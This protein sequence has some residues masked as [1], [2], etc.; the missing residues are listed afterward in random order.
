MSYLDIDYFYC[1]NTRQNFN[2]MS[3]SVIRHRVTNPNLLEYANKNRNEG[4]FND[5]TIFAG[6]ESIPAN[7]L[8]LSCH[9]KFFEGMLKLILREENTIEIEVIDGTTMKALIDFIYTG[10][11]TIDDQNVE[12]LKLGADYLKMDEVKEFCDEFLREKAKLHHSFARFKSAIMNKND[13]L[14]DEI[15]E[16]ISTHLDEIAQTDEFKTLSKDNLFFCISNL[17]R[18]H[19]KET[20]IYQAVITWVRHNEEVRGT[21]F[22]EL[23]KMINLNEIAKDFI[24]NAILKENLVVNNLE[25]HFQA[26]STLRDLVMN[27]TSKPLESHLIRLGGRKGGKKVAVVFSLFKNIQKKYPTSDLGLNCHCSLKLN[28][29]IYT[30]GGNFKRGDDF[31]TTNEVVKLNLKDENA[32]WEKVASM[33]KKRYLMGASVYRGTLFV[34]GGTD[35]T[36]NSLVSCEYYLPESNEWKYA[37][38]LTQP[39][40]GLALVACDG[41]LYALGGW[42]DYDEEDLISAEKLNH[43]DGEWQSI[44]PMQTPIRKWL[45]AVNCDGVVYAIG[46]ESG[47]GANTTKIKSVEKYDSARNQWK[48]VSDM[49]FVRSAHAACVLRGKIYVVGGLYSNESK[50]NEIECYDPVNETWSIVGTTSDDLFHHTLVAV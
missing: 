15:R 49:N 24:Q 27:K 32:N 3:S 21:V 46:G 39:R 11:I 40:H 16:Y 8:V 41:C 22:P 23:F 6:N 5:F 7:R 18:P 37:S 50:E 25:C 28:D 43:F 36:G 1:T 30:M 9:S 33:N 38:P 20:S 19:A 29:H 44:Q 34:A 42:D 31:F 10:S 45:A 47:T 35:E 14:N 48:Y 17:E 13:A 12:T 4:F 26:I 2:I